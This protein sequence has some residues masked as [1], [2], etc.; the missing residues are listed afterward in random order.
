[1]NG[2]ILL[3]EDDPALAK[4]LSDLL[5]REGYTLDKSAA[6]ES[7]LIKSRSSMFDL[8]IL[9]TRLPL[10]NGFN[11]CRDLRQQG[12]DTP[13][14]IVLEQG[15]KAQDRV[16]GLRLG[17]DD[18]L[19]K[20][21]DPSELLARIEAI[22]RRSRVPLLRYRFGSVDVDFRTAEIVKDGSIVTLPGK[23][24]ELLQVLITHRG[25]ILSRE[26]LLQR[27]WKYRLGVSSRTVDVH[28]AA[29]RQKLEANPESPRYILTIR[30]AG[31]KFAP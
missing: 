22:L 13:I 14:V 30:G 26:E 4:I 8:L 31:Y 19:T 12:C 6:G 27:I 29:L 9:D 18:C 15:S 3:A 7:A 28:V 10:N 1:L 2:K 24:L 11:L 16:L 17:A 23:Q 5:Q 20:P 25:S 21:L